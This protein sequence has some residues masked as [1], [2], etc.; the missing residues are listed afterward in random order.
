MD[1]S[2][3]IPRN[4]KTV[5]KEK[6]RKRTRR[7]SKVGVEG[8]KPKAWSNIGVCLLVT[9]TP[10][11]KMLATMALRRLYSAATKRRGRVK[12][13]GGKEEKK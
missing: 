1:L 8:E 9:P 5:R 3:W 7:E 11:A 13:S 6:R 2:I 4:A 12:D 10:P